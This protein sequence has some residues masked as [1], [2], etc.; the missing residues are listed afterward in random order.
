M[1]I[2]DACMEGQWDDAVNSYWGPLYS[3]LLTQA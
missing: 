2:A 3:W 1:E